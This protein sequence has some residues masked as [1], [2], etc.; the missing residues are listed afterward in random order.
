MAWTVRP[1][2]VVDFINQRWRSYTGMSLDEDLE[3]HKRVVHPEDRPRVMEK[4]LADVAAGK[5]YEDEMRLLGADGNYRWFLV[6][7]VPLR[8]DEGKIIKWYGSSNDIE[9]RKRAENELRKQK[10]ILQKI[11][12]NV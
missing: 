11:F 5:P 6:R 12:D 4:W 2:G 8:D 1:D 3:E 10:E 7:T 9:D